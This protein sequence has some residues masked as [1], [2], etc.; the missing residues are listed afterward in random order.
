M[1]PNWVWGF[2]RMFEVPKWEFKHNLSHLCKGIFK[3][4]HRPDLAPLKL[5]G[6]FQSIKQ[7]YNRLPENQLLI[8]SL[9]P[10]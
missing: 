8:F 3:H 10:Y 9:N 4:T 6:A 1:I 5:T 7:S 2:K